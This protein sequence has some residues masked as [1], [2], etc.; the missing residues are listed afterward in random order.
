MINHEDNRQYHLSCDQNRVEDRNEEEAHHPSE[1]GQ[2]VF[3]SLEAIEIHIGLP[4]W[5]GF[6]LF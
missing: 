5:D 6:F 1:E 2:Y 3:Q 4:R